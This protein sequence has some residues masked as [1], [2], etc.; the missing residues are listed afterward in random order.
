MIENLIKEIIKHKKISKY[1]TCI[2][3][4]KLFSISKMESLFIYSDGRCWI[5]FTNGTASSKVMRVYKIDVSYSMFTKRRKFTEKLLLDIFDLFFCI[6]SR[7]MCLISLITNYIHNLHRTATWTIALSSD[8]LAPDDSC[9]IS[10][11]FYVHQV[12]DPVCIIDVPLS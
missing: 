9:H 1:I 5:R 2:K 3:I 10:E 12:S 4:W 11:Y 8:V 7:D 6:T